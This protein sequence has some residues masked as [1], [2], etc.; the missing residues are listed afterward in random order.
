MN[1]AIE[2]FMADAAAMGYPAEAVRAEVH[3]KAKAELT[4]RYDDIRRGLRKALEE[5]TI[6]DLKSVVSETNPTC[7]NGEQEGGGQ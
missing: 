2:R 3:R 4:S 6:D 7:T 5:M 1:Q